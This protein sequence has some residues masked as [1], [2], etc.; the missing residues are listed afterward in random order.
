MILWEHQ[1]LF[2]VVDI[3]TTSVVDCLWA[4]GAAG[5]GLNLNF[6]QRWDDS[7]QTIVAIQAKGLCGA[8]RSSWA[9]KTLT[10]FLHKR[11]T[12]SPFGW[13]EHFCGWMSFFTFCVG[14]R[15][16]VCVHVCVCTCVCVYMGV[17]VYMCVCVHMCEWVRVFGWLKICCHTRFRKSGRH[18]FWH[19]WQTQ[20]QFNVI[21]G[22]L[23]D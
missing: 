16:C 1:F 4:P 12:S 3:K 21:F 10:H 19:S 2:G 7:T 18:C 8:T 13:N 22:K 5:M 14:L 17:C 15:E 20:F 9:K 23:L 6:T 11:K